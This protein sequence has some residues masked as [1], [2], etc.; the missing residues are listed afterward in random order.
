MTKVQQIIIAINSFSMGIVIPVFNLVLLEKGSNLQTL[1]L[2]LAIYSTTVLCLELPSGIYADI[3]GRKAV[4]LLACVFQFISFS[5]MIASNN[6]AWLVLAITFFGLGRAFS[7]GS[8]DALFIDQAIDL[9]GEDCLAKVTA[10]LAVLDGI[11]L[12]VGSIAGGI[13][14]SVTST[15]LTNIILRAAFTVVLF[16]LC[17]VFVKEKPIHNTNQ[18]VPLIKHIR[19][20]KQVIFSAPEFSFLF[21][22]VF[23][24][25]FLLCT[26]ETYW[27]S[28]FMQIPAAKNN[29]WML[30][31]ITFLGFS[32]AAFGNIIAQKL[33]DKCRN[34]WWNVYNVCRII[35]AACILVFA[36]QKNESG[37]V[38]WYTGVYLLLGA[39]N[40]AE[41]ALINKLTP[42]HMRASVLS[43]NSLV[44]QVGALCASVFSSIM[45]LRLKFSGVWIIAGGLL[46]GYAIIVTVVANK[47]SQESMNKTE[48][49]P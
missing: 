14:P 30:G 5:L 2:L 33:L 22:G 41:S 32:A 47:S 42:N 36:I 12:A 6:V 1:P 15:Y 45:I 8:L 18:H 40:V 46:G 7:S 13:I 35:F 9:H 48:L 37:F 34:R 23:F 16:I 38:L 19:Q 26:I 44:A 43:L 11:G 49:L 3:H 21:M 28:A 4:F 27:Q 20:G 10:R 17:S 25:G 29:A 24:V 31:F 39:G